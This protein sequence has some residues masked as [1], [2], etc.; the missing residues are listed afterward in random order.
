MG[1]D[2]YRVLT[3]DPVLGAPDLSQPI[4]ERLL[5]VPKAGVDEAELAADLRLLYAT[6]HDLGVSS[7]EETI[8]TVAE[9][10]RTGQIFLIVLTILT[11]VLAV[12]G[13]FAVIYVSVYGRRSEIGML[14]AVGIPGRQ[15]LSVFVGEA[16]VMTLSATVTGVIAGVLL[17]YLLRLSE[18]F[19]EEVPTLFAIDE[20]I[21]SSQLLLMLLASLVSAFTATWGFRRQRAIDVLRSI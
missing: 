15:L 17:A 14:K 4:V 21:V 12:F 11:S 20:L 13:V 8:A 10:A 16:M 7:T 19:R 5:A 1:L 6:E 2:S 3:T 18:G 9:E